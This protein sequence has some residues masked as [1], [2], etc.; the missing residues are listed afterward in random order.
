M[1]GRIYHKNRQGKIVFGINDLSVKTSLIPDEVDGENQIL[2]SFNLVN[3]GA[4]RSRFIGVNNDYEYKEFFR[5]IKENPEAFTLS[6][7]ERN[8]IKKWLRNP[9]IEVD[10]LILRN[11]ILKLGNSK[12]FIKIIDAKNLLKNVLEVETEINMAEKSSLPGLM[13]PLDMIK[14]AATASLKELDLG[15][16]HINNLFRH[17]NIN[18]YSILSFLKQLLEK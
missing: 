15:K 5:D 6:I 18:G 2:Y 10:W 17:I 8:F 14:E 7:E 12:G 9:S 1:N 16:N 3:Y 13:S 11:A 4:P